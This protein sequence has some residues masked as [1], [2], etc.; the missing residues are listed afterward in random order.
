MKCRN[1]I[2]KPTGYNPRLCQRDFDRFDLS[3]KK[4]IPRH[5]TGIWVS[6][7]FDVSPADIEEGYQRRVVQRTKVPRYQDGVAWKERDPGRSR[8]RVRE[9]KERR[10]ECS[11]VEDVPSRYKLKVLTSRKRSLIYRVTIRRV[12]PAVYF[13]GLSRGTKSPELKLYISVARRPLLPSPIL[14]CSRYP[15]FR[16]RSS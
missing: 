1:T 3:P 11:F 6:T 5:H 15:L 8:Y 4:E 2:K 16:Y 9:R 7:S 13:H 12:T 10:G 14:S